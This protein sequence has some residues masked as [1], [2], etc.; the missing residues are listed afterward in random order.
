MLGSGVRVPSA[1]P[2]YRRYRA[3]RYFGRA[4]AWFELHSPWHHLLFALSRFALLRL[5]YRPAACSSAAF[6]ALPACGL[7]EHGGACFEDRSCAP[8]R[9]RYRASRRMSAAAPVTN[10]FA[11]PYC[12]SPAGILQP[13]SGRPASSSS[14]A[15]AKQEP[16][17]PLPTTGARRCC[18]WR[19]HKAR[20]TATAGAAPAPCAPRLRG[21]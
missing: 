9:W 4:G 20:P 16:R 6:I 15:A 10:R 1:A 14:K 19:S 11:Q 5:R 7:L 8:S 2:F 12:A 17:A 13:A 18:T 3:S 21:L